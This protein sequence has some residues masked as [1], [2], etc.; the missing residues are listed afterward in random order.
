MNEKL[1]QH[2]LDQELAEPLPE[3]TAMS[4]VRADPV[5]S[6]ID[7]NLF[8]PGAQTAAFAQQ[9]VPIVQEHPIDTQPQPLPPIEST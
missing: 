2:E 1:S 3:R 7:Q 8:A 6:V 5:N 9:D 4:V